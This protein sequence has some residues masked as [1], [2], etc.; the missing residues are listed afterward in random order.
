VPETQSA[1]L[2]C[3]DEPGGAVARALSF[4]SQVGGEGGLATAAFLR[5]HDDC[6]QE[7]NLSFRMQSMIS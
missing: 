5:G 2:V 3:I 1:L 4:D 7:N 6:F